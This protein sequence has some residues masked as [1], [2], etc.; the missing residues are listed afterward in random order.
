MFQ[1]VKTRT[2]DVEKYA[3]FAFGGSKMNKRTTA[4]TTEQYKEIITTMKQ[5]FCGCR[6]NDRIA[7][8]LVLEGNLGLRISDI[9]ALRPCDVLLDG[10][11]YRLEIMEQKTGKKRV[12]TVPLVIQQYIENYC[13]R[14]GIRR[15]E[16][17]F[18]LTER[19][20]QKQLKIVCDYL[21]Y[22]GISTHSF[23]KWYAT[24]IYKANGYDIALVQRL[25]QH[26]SAST[27]QRYIGIEPQR[28]EEAIQG[29][30][31]LI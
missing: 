26:A 15:E 12:F 4:L 9:L 20:I 30:A 8:A 18:P 13:L 3:L 11:R 17:I 27:T 2:E 7:T 21:G 14:N 23:R 29:H 19:A 1:D 31:R 5:G 25:L 6:P 28:I 16:R 10:D 24:E 22:E